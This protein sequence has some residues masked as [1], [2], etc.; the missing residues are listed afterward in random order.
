MT[1]VGLMSPACLA[2]IPIVKVEED[3]ELRVLNPDPNVGGPQVTCA[4]SPTS[5]IRS[6]YAVFE[7]NHRSEPDF[8]PGGLQLQVWNGDR[9]LSVKN[10][11]KSE[12]L[13]CPGETV[14]WTQQVRLTDGSLVFEI[15]KGTSTTW[16]PF[17]GQ[18]YLKAITG[19]SLTTLAAYHPAVSIEHSGIGF[20][21][22]RVASLVLRKV[23]YYAADGTVYESA[24]PRTVYSQ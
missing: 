13:S 11:P 20:A 21:A 9:L 2:E 15:H 10:Y 17:G 5:D 23:R 8:V 18:G 1:L 12:L 6:V 14:R 4:V 24:E 7:V 22:N 16:G 19:T 3:W